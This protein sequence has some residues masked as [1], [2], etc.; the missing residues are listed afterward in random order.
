MIIEYILNDNVTPIECSLSLEEQSNKEVRSFKILRR[1]TGQV[2][3]SISFL[4]FMYSSEHVQDGKLPSNM[5]L[6]TNKECLVQKLT[7]FRDHRSVLHIQSGVNIHLHCD[8]TYR[9]LVFKLILILTPLTGVWCMLFKFILI[10]TSLIRHLVLILT[11]NVISQYSSNQILI[12]T[13]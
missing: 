10:V 2:D 4:H 12:P 5:D 1:C 8:A 3:T 6:Y 11:L 9:C 13:N 7:L